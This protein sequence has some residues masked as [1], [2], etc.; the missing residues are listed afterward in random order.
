ML[1][2]EPELVAPPQRDADVEA[3]A[4][5]GAR[6]LDDARERLADVLA[7]WAPRRRLMF[8][9]EQGEAP[10]AASLAALADDR[11]WAILIGPEGGF[12]SAERAA[13]RALDEVT[14]VSLGPRILRADTASISA[15]TLWQSCL[16]DWRV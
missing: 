2:E 9:D 15:M 10:P 11:P 1:A 8:C 16:G 5:D 13:I 3:T 12:S 7:D 6:R 14:P 4:G